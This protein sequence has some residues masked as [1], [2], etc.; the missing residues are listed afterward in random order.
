MKKIEAIIR[1]EKLDDILDVLNKA[2]INGLTVTQVLGR[3]LQ[4]GRKEYFRGNE[5]L[6]KLLQKI[7]IEL[8]VRDD[9]AEKVIGL[10]SENAKTGQ[11]GDGKIFIY[12]VEDTVRIRTGE[13]G[14]SAV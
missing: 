12:E 9:E 7:K 6:F 13:R 14:D 11:V 1:P 3:G 4:K 8:I 2:N 10:I 5:V